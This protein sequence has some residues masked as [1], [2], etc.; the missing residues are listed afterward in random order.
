MA[1][2][3][4]R[5]KVF[6]SHYKG[7]KIEVDAFIQKF[8]NEEKVFLPYVFGANENDDFIESTNTD[9]VMTQIRKK[10]YRIQQ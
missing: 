7:D 10:T 5:R 3:G 8:A 1:Y 2:Q 6:N 4:V 9:C